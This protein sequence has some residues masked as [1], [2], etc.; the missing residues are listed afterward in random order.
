MDAR[1]RQPSAERRDWKS[2]AE[3]R[4]PRADSGKRLTTDG[5][6]TSD[7]DAV[8]TDTGPAAA[9]SNFRWAKDADCR[10]VPHHG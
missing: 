5:A 8:A 6:G 10:N 1:D 9:A 3:S 4:K 2:R 7:A